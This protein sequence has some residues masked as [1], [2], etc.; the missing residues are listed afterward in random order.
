M[1]IHVCNPLFVD[2]QYRWQTDRFRCRESSNEFIVRTG[3]RRKHEARGIAGMR[4]L[5]RIAVSLFL[6]LTILQIPT[7]S[8]AQSPQGEAASTGNARAMVQDPSGRAH[9]VAVGAQI[10]KNAGSIV[11]IDDNLVV[12]KETYED[13]LGQVTKKDIEMRIRRPDKGGVNVGVY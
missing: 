3:L 10:G 2:F 8:H 13:Y 11:S 6:G 1:D 5:G 9:I 12:V 4:T 7:L